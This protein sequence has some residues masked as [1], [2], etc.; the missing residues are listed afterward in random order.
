MLFRSIEQLSDYIL[1]NTSTIGIRSYPIEKR[2]LHRELKKLQTPYGE[3]QVKIVEAPSGAKRTKIEFED[4]KGISKEVGLPIVEIQNELRGI[5]N[6]E[7]S[8]LNL[9]RINQ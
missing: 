7:F 9:K 1:E 5:L 4:L 8:N 6:S 2:K 3:I